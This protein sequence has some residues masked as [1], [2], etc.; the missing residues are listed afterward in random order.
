MKRIVML[1]IMV[2]VFLF[3]LYAEV[4]A[5][6][7]PKEVRLRMASCLPTKL[8]VIN[9][10]PYFAKQVELAS[11]GTIRFKV[12]EP[13][14]LIPAFEIA[15]A[16]SKGQIE[17]G[18]ST[19]T[20]ISGKIPAA[21]LF[22]A[23]PFGPDL[24]EYI[25]W[26]YYGNGRKLYQEMYDKYGFNVK[27]WPMLMVPMET[28]GWFRKPIKSV[29]DFK[30]M[31][32]RWPGL[33]GKV[34]SKLGASI[35]TIPGGEIFPSMERGAI[36]GTEYAC[37][38]L[39]AGA[40]LWKVAKYNYFPGWHQP[41]TAMELTINK[42][43]W[44]KFSESQQALIEMAVTDINIRAAADAEASVGK[45]LMENAQKHGV[46]NMAYPSEVL[47]ALQKAWLEVVAEES[48]N[49]PFF[50]KVWQDVNGFMKEYEVMQSLGHKTLPPQKFE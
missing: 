30:G 8:P 49:D 6:E 19:A 20:Y 11:N 10:I 36:D 32:L 2:F 1:S 34:L 38:N 41:C 35:S 31:R 12:Y 3:S 21:S 23:I 18:W 16:V 39:D 27:V 7:T 15:E 33:G 5:R 28:G 9:F 29:A 13:G 4:M 40:G 42:D 17:S 44:N 22:T 48:A 24:V 50:K 25:A 46:K 37:P 26:F 14:Q 43:T 45:V 47:I